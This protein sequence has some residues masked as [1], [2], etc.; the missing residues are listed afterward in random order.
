MIRRLFELINLQE[1]TNPGFHSVQ[2]LNTTF[3][4]EKNF[5]YIFL[6]ILQKATQQV[7]FVA[8]V[9]KAWN[10]KVS[11][12]ILVFKIR[13]SGS[14]VNIIENI[15]YKF[16]IRLPITKYSYVHITSNMMRMI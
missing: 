11:S 7:I 9:V 14:S 4:K 15:S 2:F 5:F 1:I 3:F 6:Q 12:K 13:T 8:T 16:I 10:E